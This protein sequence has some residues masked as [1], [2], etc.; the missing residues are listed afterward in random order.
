MDFRPLWGIPNRWGPDS[1]EPDSLEPDSL[2]PDRWGPDRLGMDITGTTNG[3]DE[4]SSSMELICSLIFSR[5][6]CGV[7]EPVL[8]HD[9]QLQFDIERRRP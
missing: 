4:R 5:H 6:C 2:E 1:L 8:S 3:S 7:P 9:P